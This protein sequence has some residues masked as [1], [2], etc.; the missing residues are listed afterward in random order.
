M[1]PGTNF[2]HPKPGSQILVDPIKDL[3]DVAKIRR[4]LA[5]RPR[6][7]CLFTMG[8]NTNLRMGDLLALTI[9]RVSGLRAGDS[10]TLKQQKRGRYGMRTIN[11]AVARA[12]RNW[13]SDH[14]VITPEAALF[15]GKDGYTPL[16]VPS[17]SR[18]VKC[19][20]R[21]AGLKGNFAAHTLRK[22]FGYHARVTF[23]IP[24]PVI[25]ASY[26]HKSQETTLAYLG[27]QPEEIREMFMNEL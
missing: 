4:N 25:T 23:K 13:L 3:A 6:D 11:K 22:T 12:L 14:P 17:A 5:D 8:I 9:G 15:P 27:I 2:N 10:L 21:E 19:W 1:L 7:L 18:L 26:G 24:L 16:T 20:C